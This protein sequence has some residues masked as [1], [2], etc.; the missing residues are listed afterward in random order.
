MIILKQV[1]ES[2]CWIQL[3]DHKFQ[4]IAFTKSVVEICVKYTDWNSVPV[5][6]EVVLLVI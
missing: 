5:L 3:A 6:Y 1:L 2:G 4:C